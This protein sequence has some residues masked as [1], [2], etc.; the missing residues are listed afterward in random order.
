MKLQVLAAA[1]LVASSCLFYLT[2]TLAICGQSFIVPMILGMV[3][4]VVGLIATLLDEY[5]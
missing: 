2:I 3:A 4:L 5:R 1:A